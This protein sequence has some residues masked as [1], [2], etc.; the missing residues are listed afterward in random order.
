L[1]WY[2]LLLYD[3]ISANILGKFAISSQFDSLL[4]AWYGL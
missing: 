4:M 2:Y 3:E 1:E